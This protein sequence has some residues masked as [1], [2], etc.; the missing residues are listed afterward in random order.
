MLYSYDSRVHLFD[1]V[2]YSEYTLE[3]SFI[4]VSP[5]HPAIQSTIDFIY[6]LKTNTDPETMNLQQKSPC[7]KKSYYGVIFETGPAAFSAGFN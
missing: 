1:Y 6:H 2:G 3:S 5:H 7:F 4:G